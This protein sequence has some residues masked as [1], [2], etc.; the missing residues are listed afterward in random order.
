MAVRRAKPDLVA[1]RLREAADVKAKLAACA[2]PLRSAISLVVSALK[3]G[4]RIYVFGNGGSAADAQHLAAEL[5]GRFTRERRGLPVLALTSNTSTLTAIG[6]DF[7]YERVF[8]R[9]V[10]AHVREGD[11]VIALSTSGKSKNVL[12]AVHKARELKAAV[13]G[14]TGR[15]G[16]LLRSACDVVLAAPSDDTARIQECHGTLMHILCEAVETALFG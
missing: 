10:E 4:R 3:T 13:I 12:A 7:G 1:D 8:S 9:Q 11:V 6:N 16:G 2:E 5:E 14:M 15:S